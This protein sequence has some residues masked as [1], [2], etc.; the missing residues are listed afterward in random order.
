[1]LNQTA[2]VRKTPHPTKERVAHAQD[3]CRA[4]A[5]TA[6]HTYFIG[7]HAVFCRLRAVY[8]PHSSRFRAKEDSP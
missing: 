4:V 2:N 8:H 3:V 5:Y 6:S 1:M 7:A